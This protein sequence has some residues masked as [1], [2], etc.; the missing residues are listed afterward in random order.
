MVSHVSWGWYEAHELARV[1]RLPGSLPRL[2]W[3]RQ[4]TG[5]IPICQLLCCCMVPLTIAGSMAT[6]ATTG[7]PSSSATTPGHSVRAAV[8]IQ[9]RQDLVVHLAMQSGLGGS[10]PDHKDTTRVRLCL[11]HPSLPQATKCARP[12]P[13]LAPTPLPSPSYNVTSVV[14]YSP[15]AAVPRSFVT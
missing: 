8:H 4:G 7:R 15:W 9:R 12:L 6:S 13:P 2:L 14:K 11:A 5:Q 3:Q 10:R 1:A